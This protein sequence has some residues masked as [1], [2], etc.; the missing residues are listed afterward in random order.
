MIIEK[1]KT[2]IYIKFL[3]KIIIFLLSRSKINQDPKSKPPSYSAIDKGFIVFYDVSSIS[4]NNPWG[5]DWEGGWFTLWWFTISGYC[6]NFW[7]KDC[8]NG[9]KVACY[10]GNGW[11]FKMFEAGEGAGAIVGLYS[12]NPI[13]LV[14]CCW[15]AENWLGP[16]LNA[17]LEGIYYYYYGFEKLNSLAW[18]PKLLF[19]VI[20]FYYMYIL[21]KLH[22]NLQIVLH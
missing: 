11:L 8:W 3:F 2:L 6:A 17:S 1:Y 10:C 4:N 14:L 5:L 9:S 19:Y 18:P 20:V 13:R 21:L 15:G 16:K 12:L 7:G 22:Q